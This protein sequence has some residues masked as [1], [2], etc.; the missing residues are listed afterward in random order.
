MAEKVLIWAQTKDGTIAKDGSIPWHVQGDM[1]FFAQKTKNQ[2]VLMGRNTMM[3]LHGQ[4][5]PNR[6]N[7]VLTHQKD[8]EVPVGF[9]KVY[10]IETAEAIAD[11]EQK[12]L[13][14]IGGKGIYDSYLPIADRLLVTYLATDYHGD[15]MLDPIE[16]AWKK[17]LLTEGEADENNDYAYQIWN[18][19]RP[20]FR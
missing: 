17:E 11:E 18:Y 10:S 9:K 12:Q 1:K 19:Y 20:T 14:V 2:V 15:V 3:S 7:L 13:M 4:P 5:L 8:L 6:I 16:G